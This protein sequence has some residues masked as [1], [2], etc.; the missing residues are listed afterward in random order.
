MKIA[1]ASG[2]GHV[3]VLLGGH[4]AGAA[5]GNIARQKQKS[6]VSVGRAGGAAAQ[7]SYYHTTGNGESGVVICGGQHGLALRRH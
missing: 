6:N 2:W 7:S 4:A 1:Y 5:C 3:L